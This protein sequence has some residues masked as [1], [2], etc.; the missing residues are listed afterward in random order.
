MPRDLQQQVANDS[1]PAQLL[2]VKA[3]RRRTS[4]RSTDDTSFCMRQ[5]SPESTRIGHHLWMRTSGQFC[6]EHDRGLIIYSLTTTASHSWPPNRPPDILP[7]GLYMRPDRFRRDRP[8]LSFREIVPNASSVFRD[9]EEGGVIVLMLGA[10]VVC[11]Y[12]ARTRQ[13]NRVISPLSRS[14]LSASSC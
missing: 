4:I 11:G 7:L 2:P 13:Q 1:M 14:S 6:N 3:R 10:R 5:V 12:V 8:A 9:L